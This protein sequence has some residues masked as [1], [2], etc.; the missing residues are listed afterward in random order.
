MG[1]CSSSSCRDNE[2]HHAVIT[3]LCS[4]GYFAIA[5]WRLTLTHAAEWP[6]LL[7]LSPKEC[8][9]ALLLCFR[10]YFY[11]G[12]DLWNFASQLRKVSAGR[13][14]SF[15]LLFICSIAIAYSMGQI[16]KSVCVCQS[17]CPSVYEHY[18]GRISWSIFTK[19]GTD[20][21]TLTRKNEFVKG[22][23]RTTPSPILPSP[24]LGQQVL[25]THAN[26]K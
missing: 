14:A 1:N 23:Y 22:Q 21:R 13:E 16:I 11:S 15:F 9:Y 8:L 6:T 26:I 3:A 17:V 19:I 2:R 25:K 7:N 12:L 4:D 24:I 5:R 10:I 20:V 18:H